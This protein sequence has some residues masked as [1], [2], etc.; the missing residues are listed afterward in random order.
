MR[1]RVCAGS[2]SG[3]AEHRA[4]H[5]Q[6]LGEVHVAVEAPQQVLAAPAQALDAPARAAPAASSSRR[7]RARPARVEDLDP[8][9]LRPSTS[10]ASWR[11]IVSTSGSSGIR[12]LAYERLARGGRRA[13]RP[14]SQRSTLAPTS[15][16]GPSWRAPPRPAPACRRRASIAPVTR[17]QRR[18]LARVVGAGVRRD[19]RRGRRSRSA[20]HPRAG[21]SSMSPQRDVDLA[22]RVARSRARPCDGR[23]RWSVS[24][25]F[26][27]TR[28]RCSSPSSSSTASSARAFVAPRVGDA[29]ADAGEQVV[30]LADAV[31]LHARRPRAPAG[32]CA[33]AAAARSRAG[34]RCARTRP[35]RR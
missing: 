15:A 22:Q 34:R 4:C 18:V 12:A 24:I 5:A 3:S 7:E 33:R 23:R 14:V 21:A 35:R 13:S 11:L 28:P 17:Q 19:R 29:D 31:H 30:D 6:V 27:N 1:T 25:R 26:A 9:N 8:L 2:G 20:G 10:G 16:S 32:S